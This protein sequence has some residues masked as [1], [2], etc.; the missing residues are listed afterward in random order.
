MNY[1]AE[2][3]KFVT[4]QYIFAGVRMTLACVVPAIILAYFGLLKDYFLF[5]LATSFVGLTD[6]PGPFIR[7]RNS[8]LMAL[9]CFT[10]VALISGIARSFVPLVF[11]EILISG[12][13]FTMI[14]V[15][16]QRL[17]SV[18]SIALVVMAIFVDHGIAGGSV[19]KNVAVLFA[20]CSWFIIVFLIVSKIQPYK[21][22]SQMVGENYLELGEFLRIKAKFY[23]PNPDYDKLL[24]QVISKQIQIKNQ[25]EATRETVFKTRTIVNEA[26]TSSRLLMMMFLNSLDLHEKLMTSENDYRKLQESF[27]EHEILNQINEYLLLLAEEI[28][29]IGIALQTGVK[30]KSLNN[31]AAEHHRLYEHYFQF[32]N[33]EMN[34]E[35]LGNFMILRQILMRINEITDDIKNIYSVYSQDVSLAKSL[36]SGLDYQKFVP[37]EEKLN[38]KVLKN[39]LSLNSQHFRH[40]IRITLALLIGYSFSF[41]EFLGVGHSYWILITIIAILKP[42]YSITKSR[43]ILRLYG[44]IAGGI[45]AYILLYFIQDGTILLTILLSSMVLCFTLLR[46]NYM[47]AVFFMTI[48]IFLTFNALHPGNINTIFKDRLLDTAIAGIIAFAVSYLIL[49]VWEHSHNIDCMKASAQKTK[50]YFEIVLKSLQFQEFNDQKYRLSRKDA[51]IALA[52]L[53]DNF[54]RMISDPKGQQHKLESVHQFVTTSHLL[55]AYTASLSQ[56]AKKGTAYPDIDFESWNTKIS[57]ELARTE[58]ILNQ[59]N[60]EHNFKT[61]SNIEPEDFVHELLEQRKKEIEEMEFYDKRDIHKISYVA[62]IKNIREILVLIYNTAEEQRKIVENY[63]KTN[64]QS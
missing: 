21:L 19:L 41:V 13:L 20:G 14:G 7:R 50:S 25:Q 64:L 42:S 31:Y 48:Y 53:Y 27:G 57:A 2:L 10:L 15:Y 52:N 58:Y 33:K 4:S 35:N 49:P 9:C 38:F 6:V 11:L 34:A 23:Q 24:Q 40:A 1:K 8:L 39:N 3:Q 61:E 18:G 62:E 55:T 16:G 22:A 36:S 59:E 32:R 46:G 47:V 63:Y 5:P 28:S 30:A 43:N 60:Y 26:T 44:T 51:M 45:F 54:Q 56:Y 29:N 12:M 37:K 17:A